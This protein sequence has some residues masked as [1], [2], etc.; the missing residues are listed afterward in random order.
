[1]WNNYK[2]HHFL[3]NKITNLGND[4]QW[5]ITCNGQIWGKADRE[6]Y[7]GGFQLSPPESN[8]VITKSE[9]AR[10]YTSPDVFQ[11]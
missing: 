7:N 11:N 9:T 4:H 6:L 8:P 10:Y 2:N 3:I 1:M 5:M